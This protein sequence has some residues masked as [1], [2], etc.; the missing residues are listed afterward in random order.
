MPD[1]HLEHIMVLGGGRGNT[2]ISGNNQIEKKITQ[3]FGEKK[4]GGGLRVS[5]R[6]LPLITSFS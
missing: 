6:I 3:D 5:E 2:K 1:V 4:K